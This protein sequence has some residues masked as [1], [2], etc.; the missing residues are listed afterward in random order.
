MG[1]PAPS[2]KP[3]PG[4]A[5]SSELGAC[6][7]WA[8]VIVSCGCISQLVICPLTLLKVLFPRAVF[9]PF[10]VPVRTDSG[11]ACG[12][13]GWGLDDLV[14]SPQ[15]LPRH[16]NSGGSLCPPHRLCGSGSAFCLPCIRVSHATPFWVVLIGASHVRVRCVSSV[17]LEGSQQLSTISH[18]LQ[19]QHI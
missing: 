19:L 7:E 2:S 16:P 14:Y 17:T 9:L 6:R 10:Y 1:G 15:A 3:T 5:D 18:G 8:P 13:A 11:P 12:F 4:L